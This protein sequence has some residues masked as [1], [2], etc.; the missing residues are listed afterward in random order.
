MIIAI[1]YATFAV[2]KRKPEKKIKIIGRALHRYRMQRSRVRIPY[3]PEFF[4]G[5][6]FATAK[7][8]FTTAMII[9]HL[10]LMMEKV[11]LL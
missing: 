10:I 2:A 5:F 11:M 3:K 9:L 4:S 1:T 8:A 6:L 7:V